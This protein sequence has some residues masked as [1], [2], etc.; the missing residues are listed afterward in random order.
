METLGA[1]LAG[2]LCCLD[3]TKLDF[4]GLGLVDRRTGALIFF[5]ACWFGGVLD[6]QSV[7]KPIEESL[8]NFFG[9]AGA[10]KPTSSRPK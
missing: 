6:S 1:G 7:S 10:A 4:G 8:N 5:S 9:K 2:V 3:L